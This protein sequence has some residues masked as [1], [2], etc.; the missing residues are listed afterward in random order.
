MTCRAGPAAAVPQGAAA[1]AHV[2][3]LPQAQ[4]GRLAVPGAAAAHRVRAA[5]VHLR[6]RQVQGPARH[7]REPQDF[8]REGEGGQP[9]A[10]QGDRGAGGQGQGQVRGL[11]LLEVQEGEPVDPHN[12]LNAEV[13][14]DSLLGLITAPVPLL[15]RLAHEAQQGD[16]RQRRPLR[17]HGRVERVVKFG[18]PVCNTQ[19]CLAAVI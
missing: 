10:R 9:R 7:A 5:R 14:A 6:R 2:R 11:P 4:A 18:R 16:G 17:P 3:G 13:F 19:P 8:S 15:R 12:G 1:A